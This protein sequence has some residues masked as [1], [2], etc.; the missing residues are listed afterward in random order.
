M[1]VLVMAGVRVRVKVKVGVGVG[2]MEELTVF[3]VIMR[4][5]FV[6]FLTRAFLFSFGLFFL[7]SY[8]KFLPVIS[9]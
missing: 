2:V 4:W 8:L 5:V 9:F 7:Y 3:L 6:G 1:I